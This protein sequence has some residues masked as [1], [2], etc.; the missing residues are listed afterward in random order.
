M[1]NCIKS[2]AC[3]QKPATDLISA[4]SIYLEKSLFFKCNKMNVP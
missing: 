2:V 3:R 4:H 1:S